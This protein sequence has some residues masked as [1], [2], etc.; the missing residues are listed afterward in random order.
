MS[1]K[2]EQKQ[3]RAERNLQAAIESRERKRRQRA[4]LTEEKAR[5]TEANALMR[6]KLQN[7][8]TICDNPALLAALSEGAVKPGSKD[9]ML[10]LSEALAG[11]LGKK[12]VSE[13]AIVDMLERALAGS[14]K[15]PPVD[16]EAWE[17]WVAASKKAP[18]DKTKAKGSSSKGSSAGSSSKRR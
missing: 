10:E 3:N 12:E 7:T 11:L 6:A 16:S 13:A 8:P 17:R 18:K 14:G 5:L 2:K 9:G 4:A 15:K 1:S